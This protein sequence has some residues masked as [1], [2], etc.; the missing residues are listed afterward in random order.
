ME[1]NSN[2]DKVIDRV[3]KKLNKVK[4]VEKLKGEIA[5]HLLASNVERVHTRARKVDGS[6]I[7]TYSTRPT[8]VGA[9]SFRTEQGARSV[10]GT[11]AKRKRLNWR[12]VNTRKGKRNLALLPGGYK[13]IRKLDGDR[14]N[15]VNLKR[16]TKLMYDL[17]ILS[18]GKIW[19]IGFGK[20]G[21]KLSQHLEDKYGKVWG[22]TKK[23][24]IKIDEIIKDHINRAL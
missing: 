21:A 13:Q 22:V 23:D 7:G 19:T 17:R 8:F 18:R 20:Y 11:P 16:T 14:Y 15:F 5:Q 2:M 24:S 3:T 9:S 4:E 6:M 10:F 12:K 1:F